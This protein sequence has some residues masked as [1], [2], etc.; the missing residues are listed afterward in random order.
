MTSGRGWKIHPVSFTG[1]GPSNNHQYL[2]HYLLFSVSLI[3]TVLIE[4]VPDGHFNL[5]TDTMEGW[6]VSRR[7]RSTGLLWALELAWARP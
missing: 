3:V 2:L 6:A 4:A 1:H 7:W 5:L